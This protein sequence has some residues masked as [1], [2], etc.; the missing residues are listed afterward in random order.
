MQEGFTC[1]ESIEVFIDELFKITG[2]GFTLI[3]DNASFHKGG[4]IELIAKKHQCY[5]IYL[6]SYSPD[7]NPIECFWFPIKNKI[8]KY[9]SYFKNN[10]IDAGFAAFRELKHLFHEN[11]LS[12]SIC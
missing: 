11:L 10:I 6:P 2:F 12:R 7:F 1:R 3:M 8:R 4:K 9:L 5:I